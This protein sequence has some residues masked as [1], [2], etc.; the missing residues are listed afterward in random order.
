MK[1]KLSQIERARRD[2]SNRIKIVKNGQYMERIEF[3]DISLKWIRPSK[4]QISQGLEGG[5]TTM[6]PLLLFETDH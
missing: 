5:L 6:L 3:V 2:T 4:L 1:I